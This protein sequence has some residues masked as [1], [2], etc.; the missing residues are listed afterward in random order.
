MQQTKT[1][2]SHPDRF[3]GVFFFLPTSPP[4]LLTLYGDDYDDDNGNDN[5]GSPILLALYDRSTSRP[6]RSCKYFKE[7]DTGGNPEHQQPR[8]HLHHRHPEQHHQVDPQ[9]KKSSKK[10]Q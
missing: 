7:K 6:K 8:H 3:V 9:K 1:H 10:S 5:D 2:E 4:V